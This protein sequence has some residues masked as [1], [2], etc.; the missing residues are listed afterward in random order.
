MLEGAMD[1]HTNGKIKSPSRLT[2]DADK[3][4]KSIGDV[5]K[6]NQRGQAE[7]S[8]NSNILSSNES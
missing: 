8:S 1:G 3:G 2:F 7:N 6:M 4:R 5:S